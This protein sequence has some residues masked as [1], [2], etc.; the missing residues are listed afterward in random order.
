MRDF[1]VRNL[2]NLK[3]PSPGTTYLTPKIR[4]VFRAGFKM[5]WDE[6][7]ARLSKMLFGSPSNA[8]SSLSRSFAIVFS[9]YF[10]RT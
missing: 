5:G 4:V 8:S 9:G 3:N 6:R 10:L 1:L 2:K 7:D